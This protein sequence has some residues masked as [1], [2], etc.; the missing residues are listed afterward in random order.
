MI[1]LALA[2]AFLVF[3]G[4]GWYGAGVLNPT[5][6]Q[7][8]T[9]LSITNSVAPTTLANLIVPGNAIGPT[10]CLEVFVWI[11]FLNNTG[12]A[13]FSP[14][15][16]VNLGG[17]QIGGPGQTISC[18]TN[19]NPYGF[20]IHIWLKNLNA[21]NQQSAISWNVL[22][23]PARQFT[24]NFPD[25][26]DAGNLRSVAIDLT[27]NQALTVVVTNGFADPLE[28]TFYDGLLVRGT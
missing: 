14:I 1:D 18:N 15:I 20:Y 4:V 25:I 5:V 13:R 23:D 17:V 9:P 3:V 12:V 7:D 11:R 19:A 22:T 27:Q 16:T 2:L 21:S 26:I 28:T 10:G 8:S 6:L 24:V